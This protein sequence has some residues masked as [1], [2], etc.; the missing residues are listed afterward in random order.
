MMMPMKESTADNLSISPDQCR[1]ARALVDIDQTWLAVAA[2]LSRGV[3]IDF[4]EGRRTPG[5]DNLV[6]IRRALEAAGVEFTIGG[7]PG[8]R[9]RTNEQRAILHDSGDQSYRAGRIAHCFGFDARDGARIVEIRVSE[10]ALDDLEV[11]TPRGSDYL[12]ILERNRD[13]IF[14]AGRRLYENRRFEPDGAILVRSK[15]IAP[16]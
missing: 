15:D 12:G 5:T 11:T 16:R 1:A 2:S 6:A 7:Q 13:R 14:L 4:E 9:K 10:I 3:V 8:V